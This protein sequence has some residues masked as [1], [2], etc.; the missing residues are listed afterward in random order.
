M[1][2]EIFQTIEF[3]FKAFADSVPLEAFVFVG[4]GLEEIFS[5]IPA[6]LVMGIA[7]SA[8]LLEGR[9]LL[10]L[11]FLSALG[12]IGRLFGAYFYYWLGDK[13]EDVLVPYMKKIFGVGHAEIESIGKRFTGHHWKD[14]G[15][16]FLM[17]ITPFFPV[18]V[19]S[20]AC[21]V[22]KMNPRV[23]LGASFAGNFLKDFGYLFLGY[24]GLAS[25][26]HLWQDI[27][28][29]KYYTDILTTV[30]IV[31]FFAALYFFRGAGKR[32]Y[33]QTRQRLKKWVKKT[34]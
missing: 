21:G 5:I 6:S 12:N 13:L 15:A 14:G 7:G 8:A 17:R 33:Y 34:R 9:S 25:L 16:L 26:N 29:Y 28:S 4:S 24:V 31:L 3:G 2:L 30:V 27:H 1:W 32:I 10:Y 20:I 18:T 19:T 11:V 23:Y 22:I